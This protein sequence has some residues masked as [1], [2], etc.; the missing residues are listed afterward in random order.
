[1]SPLDNVTGGSILDSTP[2]AVL[3]GLVVVAL[4]FVVARELRKVPAKLH[5][6]MFTAFLDMVGALM[7]APLLPFY[8]QRMGGGGAEVGL[9]LSSFSAAQLLSAPLWG[10]FSDRFGRRPT[11]LV[12]LFASAIAFLIFGYATSLAMLFFSRLVLGAGGGTVGVIQAYVADATEPK[13]R[14]KSLGWLSAATNAGVALGP[15]LGSWAAMVGQK[16]FTVGASA[17]SI[18]PAAPGI[19]AASLCL[20]NIVFAWH[21][22]KEPKPATGEH[23]VQH[24]G[25]MAAKRSSTGGAALRVLSHPSEPA[26]RLIWIYAIAM[27]AFTAAIGMLGLFLSKE[28]QIT[29]ATI[30]PFF[31]YIGVISVLTRVLVLGRL[32][33]RLGEPRLSRLGMVL[34]AM[35]LGG[36]PFANSIATLAIFVALIPLGTAFTFPCVTAMLSRVIP[37]TERGLYMGLQQTFGGIAR[38]AL[39]TVMGMTFDRVGHGWPF[40]LSAGLVLATIPLGLGMEGYLKP[41]QPAPQAA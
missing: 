20:L 35:G 22:L 6:L 2:A 41:K 21:Y 11:L 36:L 3:I 9:L 15:V 8:A 10:R 37:S 33:D 26:S 38:V 28:F 34:L 24:A 4:V 39:P 25:M 7:L 23:P 27:G 13:D 19:L 1:M 29:E 31:L 30:G 18:G 17:F 40:W 14:A 16:T 12:A 32:V 5:V